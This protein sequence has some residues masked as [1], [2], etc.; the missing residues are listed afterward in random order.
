[1]KNISIT[2]FALF[3]VLSY[4][5]QISYASTITVPSTINYQGVIFDNSNNP[6][7]IP[8]KFRFSLWSNSDYISS[9]LTSTGAININNSA[10]SSY[11]E[12]QIITPD[13]NGNFQ[14]SIGLT[15]PL[16]KLDF[17]IHKYLQVEVKNAEALDTDYALLDVD[18][19]V[20][21]TND[22]KRLGSSPYALTADR[23]DNK[24][25][26]YEAGNIPSLNET[27]KLP[28]TTIPNKTDEQ[29][30]TIN[31]TDKEGNTSLKFS[32]KSEIIWDSTLNLLSTKSDMII[33]GN[34]TINKNT[35]V[36]GIK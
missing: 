26:G 29:D 20:T 10:W 11:T 31:A 2:L 1:M 36:K 8:L 13:I 4:G 24:D 9:D 16:P 18:N 17:S 5:L 34:L 6:I 12:E 19:D 7:T 27:G 23:V 15:N 25:V 21:N 35:T 28:T 22:R 33:E 30:F 32:N 14:T 3:F